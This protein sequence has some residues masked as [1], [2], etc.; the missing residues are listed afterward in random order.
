MDK[1]RSVVIRSP[2]QSRPKRQATVKAQAEMLKQIDT[3][4]DSFDDTDE[5]EHYRE[6][7]NPDSTSEEGSPS[8][9]EK[10]TPNQTKGE[11]K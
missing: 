9:D 11:R 5:D 2:T 4:A 10:E 3:S 8:E 1:I 7:Q 6:P